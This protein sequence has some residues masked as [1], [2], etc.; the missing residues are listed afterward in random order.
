MKLFLLAARVSIGICVAASSARAATIN[1]PP[2]GSLQTAIINARPGDTIALEAGATYTG[3]F[4][5]PRRTGR[6]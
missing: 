4:N 2:N 1:V 6:C 3:N 5:F